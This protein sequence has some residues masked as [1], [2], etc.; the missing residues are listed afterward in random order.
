MPKQERQHRDRSRLNIR[1]FDKFKGDDDRHQAKE[2][3][4]ATKDIL[5]ETLRRILQQKL[6][7]S[8]EASEDPEKYKIP[9]W[10]SLDQN[11]LGYRRAL[12]EV[13][14]LLP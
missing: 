13:L 7:A 2:R 4:I 1:L 8:I 11:E 3:Y 10:E 12:R 9:G 5:D 14:N 6:D